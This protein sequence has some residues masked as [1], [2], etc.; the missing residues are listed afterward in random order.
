MQTRRGAI[1]WPAG[2]IATRPYRRCTWRWASCLSVQRT[3]PICKYEWFAINNSAACARYNDLVGRSIMIGVR[4]TCNNT[5]NMSP[6][7]EKRRERE[8]RS[9][10]KNRIFANPRI[11][12]EAATHLSINSGSMI[13]F[14]RYYYLTILMVFLTSLK[15]RF[16]CNF[17]L[18]ITQLSAAHGGF[19]CALPSP[20][21]CRGDQ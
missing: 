7:A 2:L 14:I 6:R 19:G 16:P 20:P 3:P 12:Y 15:L 17:K 9:R 13:S 4:Y 1:C 18:A 8:R 11:Y 21:F 10:A 5:H